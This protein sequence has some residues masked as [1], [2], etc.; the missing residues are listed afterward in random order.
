[1]QFVIAVFRGTVRSGALFGVL[2]AA[3]GNYLWRRWRAQAPLTRSQRVAWMQVWVRWVLRVFGVTYTLAGPVPAEGL[4]VSN[5]LGYLDIMVLAAA[6]PS[7]FVSKI[8]VRRWPLFGWLAQ[9]GGTIFVQ[10]RTR[11]DLPAVTTAMA[12]VLQQGQTVVLFPEGTSSNGEK[13]LPFHAALFEAAV[14]AKVPVMPAYLRYNTPQGLPEPHAYYWGDAILLP[15][16]AQLLGT[17][18]ICAEVV[19][20]AESRVFTDRH[21]AATWARGVIEELRAARESS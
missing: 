21:A 14:Q 12:E 6:H 1:M 5:H 2:L 8:E 17:K 13:I 19:F 18:R 15:H 9:C 20:S 3:Q 4:L 10:R 16:I 11:D 7:V